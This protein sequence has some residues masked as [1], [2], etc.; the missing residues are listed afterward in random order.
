M[1]S[2]LNFLIEIGKLK[3]M[4][5]TGWIWLGV[6]NPETIAQ[7][8]F[9]VA[10]MSWILAREVEPKL[11]LGKIIKNS[12]VHD[13]CEVYAGDMT[14]YW[15]LLP[16]DAKKRRKTLKR[17]IRLTKKEKEKRDKIKFE[18]E[19]KSLQKLIKKLDRKLKKEIMDNW[20]DYEKLVSREGRFVK[21]VDKI[22]TLLQAKEYWK[23][24]K[25]SPVFGWW[26]EISE[27]VD[28]PV[29]L[30]FLEEVKK[31]NR[32]VDLKVSKLEFFAEIN[33]LK[34]MP[35]TGLLFRGIKNPETI[36]EQSFGTAIMTWVLGKRKRINMEKALKIALVHEIC[37]VYSGDAT[38]YDSILPLPREELKEMFLNPSKFSK[39]KRERIYQLLHEMY[40]RWPKFS[41]KEKQR[42]F[43]K[44]Y[45][46]EK[47]AL[48]K[49]TSKLSKS[50]KEEIIGLWDDFKRQ[51]SREGKFV[52][53]VYWLQTYFQTLQYLK[54]NRQFPIRPWREQMIHFIDDSSLLELFKEMEEKFYPHT[55]KLADLRKKLSFL[56]FN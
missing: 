19:K 35:R 6:K 5:R 31:Q 9:R 3:K 48:E 41:R 11:N 43:K 39:K 29:L 8:A 17:W 40:K 23:D 7:H 28:N 34:Q 20:L 51:K 42:L 32:G 4:P 21:Q 56:G 37:E 22:E 54:E 53:Q 47:R 30:E 13:L 15:G 55:Q 12:L 46:D 26:E 49:L 25:S 50:L 33:K 2:L 18:K 36:G 27:L 14:P 38:P 10:I 16:Q 1:K 52:N 44:D 45:Q 24:T